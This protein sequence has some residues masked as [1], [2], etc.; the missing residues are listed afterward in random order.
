[1]MLAFRE[2]KDV[3]VWGMVDDQ[4]WLQTFLPCTDDVLKRP[5]LYDKDYKAMAM[6]TSLADAFRGAARR[7]ALV[8]SAIACRRPVPMLHTCAPAARRALP[9]L[10]LDS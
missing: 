4:S 9:T 2:L 10:Y 6:R 1:M 3:R 7:T 5:T 8:C